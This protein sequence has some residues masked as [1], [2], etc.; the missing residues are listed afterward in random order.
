MEL[1]LWAGWTF[2]L[3]ANHTAPHSRTPLAL[4]LRVPLLCVPLLCVLLHVPL[5]CVPL[6]R[7]LLRVPRSMSPCSVSPYSVLLHVPLLHVLLHV[8]LLCVPL[9]VSCSMSTCFVSPAL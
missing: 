6:L 7:V 2:R 3:Q 1:A 4:L 8:P 5:L 9:S